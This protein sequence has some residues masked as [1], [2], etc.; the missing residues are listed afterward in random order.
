MYHIVVYTTI[1]CM[2]SIQYICTDILLLVYA[3]V[4]S[5]NMNA[6]ENHAS[7]FELAIRVGHWGKKND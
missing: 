5:R 3:V 2:Y 1:H 7:G 4:E 6:F